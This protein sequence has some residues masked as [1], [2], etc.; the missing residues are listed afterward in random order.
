MT[1]D[2]FWAEVAKLLVV[3]PDPVVEY[4][5]YYDTD[6]N[7]TQMAM[8]APYPDDDCYI[9]VDKTHYDNYIKYKVVD[10]KPALIS[11]PSNI[12]IPFVKSDKGFRVVK[13]NAALLLL[14]EE[15]F[16]NIEYYEPRRNS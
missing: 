3:T 16:T 15:T 4:R 2:D 12:K 13:N 10:Q 9:I 6:G 14:P 8:Q 11:N 5:W 1:P 7:I